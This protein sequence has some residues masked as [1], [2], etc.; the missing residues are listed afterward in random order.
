MV[1]MAGMELP[2]KAIRQQIASAIDIIV[3]QSRFRVGQEKLYP[4]L[5]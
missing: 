5:K 4:Y 2:V 3:H 1:M